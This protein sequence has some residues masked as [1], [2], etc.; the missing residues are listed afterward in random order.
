MEQKPDNEKVICEVVWQ[1]ISQTT[2]WE[3]REAGE[4]TSLQ[5]LDWQIGGASA[6]EKQRGGW[7]AGR[8]G[9]GQW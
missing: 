5:Y 6:G 4:L 1:Q 9:G 2:C 3:A 7:W 8:G